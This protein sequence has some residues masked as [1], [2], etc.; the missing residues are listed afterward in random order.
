MTR[1]ARGFSLIEMMIV[2]LIIGIV[3]ASVAP[4]FAASLE[5]YRVQAAAQRIQADLS[6]AREYAISTSNPVTVEFSPST[7]DYTIPVLDHLD[8]QNQIYRVDLV[9]AYDAELISATLGSDATLEYDHFGQPDSDGTIV[10]QSG[11]TQQ[12]L[13]I[14]ADTGMGAVP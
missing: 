3:V 14:D 9:D 8:S 7:E 12:V 13:T 11:A 10:L 2:V 1:R 4:R 5:L 6:L